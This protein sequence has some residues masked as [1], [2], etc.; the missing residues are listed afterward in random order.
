MS[1]LEIV[2]LIGVGIWL[3]LLTLVVLLII[4]QVGLLTIRLESPPQQFD[5]SADGL[6]IGMRIPEDVTRAIPDVL[7]GPAYLLVI[8][9]SCAPCRAL[10]ADL[11]LHPLDSETARRVTILVSGRESLADEITQLFPKEMQYIRDP[12]ATGLVRSLG[13][14]SSPFAVV[15]ESGKITD[16][17]YI[18]RSDDIANLADANS[19]SDRQRV[20]ARIEE[21]GVTSYGN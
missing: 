3:G 7:T 18:Q 11:Q 8:S 19:V 1:G 14:Q 12:D 20:R 9:A 2:A 13:I 4:R 16:K 17:A 5:A 10:A 15:A 6:A 21:K